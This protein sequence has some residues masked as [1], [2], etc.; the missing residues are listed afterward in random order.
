MRMRIRNELPN[1]GATRATMKSRSVLSC[2]L[3]LS[4]GCVPALEASDLSYRA[5]FHARFVPEEHVAIVRI[6]IDQTAGEL[7]ALNFAASSERFSGFSGEGAGDGEIV[8]DGDRVLW[9]VPRQGGSLRYRVVVDKERNGALDAR[10]NE[11]GA[12]V[13]LGDLFPPA[14]VRSRVGAVSESLVRLAG[15]AGWSFETRYGAAAEARTVIDPARRFDRPTGWAVAG[16]LGIRRD[17]IVDRRIAIAAPVVGAGAEARFRRMDMLAFLRWTLPTFTEVF[18]NFPERLLIVGAGN[19]MWRGGLAGPAS[20][21]LHT[22]RPLI[23]ENGTSALLHELVH[24]VTFGPAAER[25]D[26]VVEGLA[27][28]YS[29]EILRRT[30][31]IS[32]R[33]F[34]TAI[35][36]LAEWAANED[37]GP[38][39]PSTG[40]NTAWAVGKL[41]ALA[42]ELEAAGSSLDAVVRV[43]VENKTLNY[44]MLKRQAELEL[45]REATA[46]AVIGG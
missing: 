40:A 25:D 36:S 11:S 9:R 39:E 10:L 31:G 12:I 23:S 17:R 3:I 26:W 19:G 27:E 4:L 38:A 16:K 28:Y 20:L 34:D 21:Y 5:E 35:A 1:P 45:G 14:R 24:V 41:H 30:D 43:L 22:G 32:Q 8:R 13:R 42:A 6:T 2:W 37:G 44:S 46:L 15:P 29:L 33:R 18:T 7:R